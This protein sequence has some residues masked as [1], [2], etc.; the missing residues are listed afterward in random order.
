MMRGS[1]APSQGNIVIVARADAR[2]SPGAGKIEIKR[3]ERGK[4]L[5]DKRLES[6]ESRSAREWMAKENERNRP[7][8]FNRAQ[9]EEN[10][11]IRRGSVPSIQFQERA[12]Y[13]QVQL[14]YLRYG[15]DGACVKQ[16]Y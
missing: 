5:G 9:E 6:V 7:E 4:G 8:T 10:R 15:S 2:V 14:I 13:M 1:K 3:G 11:A 12:I 16:K